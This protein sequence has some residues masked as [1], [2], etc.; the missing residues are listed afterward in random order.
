MIVICHVCGARPYAQDETPPAM[1]FRDPY[2]EGADAEKRGFVYACR[3]HLTPKREEE[4]AK[5]ERE[6]SWPSATM[7]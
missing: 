1:I 6:L 7:R 2:S 3:E 5:R 4:I